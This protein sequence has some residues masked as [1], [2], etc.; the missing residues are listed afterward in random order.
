MSRKLDSTRPFA[1][2]FGGDD[3]G[4]FE[5]FGIMFD[6]AG[7]ELP[8]YDHIEIPADDAPVQVIVDNPELRGEINR[9]TS[10]I[11]NLKELLALK[12]EQFEIESGRA[13]DLAV[14]VERLKARLEEALN[15]AP[16]LPVAPVLKDCK[17]GKDVSSRKEKQLSASDLL[18]EA[19]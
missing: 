18:G 10:N 17:D 1:E 14:E 3:A 9:L 7:V 16:L 12:D 2:I 4:V 13:D 8:G 19:N 11:A 6:P 5:Q 15:P